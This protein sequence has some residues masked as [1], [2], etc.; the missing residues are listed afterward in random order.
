MQLRYNVVESHQPTSVHFLLYLE[1]SEP[2]LVLLVQRIDEMSYGLQQ[3]P[4]KEHIRDELESYGG[5]ETEG[6]CEK[7]VISGMHQECLLVPGV[8]CNMPSFSILFPY[9]PVSHLV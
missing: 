6:Q 3:Y 7:E 8:S 5:S 1:H 4:L 9:V 2:F